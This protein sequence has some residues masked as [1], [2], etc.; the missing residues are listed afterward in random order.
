MVSFNCDFS[1]TALSLGVYFSLSPV[2]RV[3]IGCT[4]NVWVW[5][6]RTFHLSM[7]ACSVIIPHHDRT[8]FF[9]GTDQ[10]AGLLHP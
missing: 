10:A 1:V 7:F 4:Q 6:V 9:R 2:N 5:S 3:P 8:W